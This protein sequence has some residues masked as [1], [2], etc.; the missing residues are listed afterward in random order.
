MRAVK[1]Y[2]QY[3]GHKRQEKKESSVELKSHWLFVAARGCSHITHSSSCSD[4]FSNDLTGRGVGGI[5]G[6]GE[7]TDLYIAANDKKV[8]HIR[9]KQIEKNAKWDSHRFYCDDT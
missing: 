6:A 5:K 8:V 1:Q 3:V 2:C 4:C 9:F 7:E